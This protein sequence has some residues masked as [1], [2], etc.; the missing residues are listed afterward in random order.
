[1]NETI[2]EPGRIRDLP[3][4]LPRETDIDDNAYLA[5]AWARGPVA[6][7]KMGFVHSFPH[8]NFLMLLDDRYTRQ[9]ETEGIRAR[10]ISSGP[11][12]DFFANSLLTSNGEVHRARRT[13]LARSFSFPLMKALRPVVAKA[14]EA[15]IAPL[16]DQAQVDVL[17]RVAGPMPAQIIAGVLGVPATDVPQFTVLVYSAIRALGARSDAIMREAE[18]D[19]GRLIE[20]VTGLLAERR[21]NPKDDFLSDYLRSVSD[22]P[23]S[24]DE[25]RITVVSLI[26]A[27]SDTT[28]AAM[29]ITF[30]RLLEHRDQWDLL[31]S[32]PD[33]WKGP[34]VEEGLRYDPVVGALARL[35][36]TGFDLSGTRIIPGTLIMPSLLTA[37]RDPAVYDRPDTFDI[38]RS[39]HPRY[40][41]AFGGGVHRCLGEALA[42]IELEEAMAA[43]A[44]HWPDATLAGPMPRMRGLTG[45]RGIDGLSV[46]PAGR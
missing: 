24:E 16:A 30:A 6:R 5:E 31:R 39:D 18:T 34:A 37:M 41:P 17:N 45:T 14:A 43:F 21:Q 36:V 13:P 20:Y 44:R 23:L 42:R 11:I 35:S 22:G 12:F 19:M 7:D 15:L 46:A 25:I 10:G 1:M 33:R 2:P 26:L 40:S 29:T 4:I 28:R 32:D 27:G 8:E 3:Q 9:V 38:T